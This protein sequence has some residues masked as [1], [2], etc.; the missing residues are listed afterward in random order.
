MKLTLSAAALAV[1]LAFAGCANS[2]VQ[3][4][5]E[6]AT[7]RDTVRRAETDPQVLSGAPLELKRATDALSKANTLF[8]KREP[9]S[10]VVSAA[11]VAQREAEAALTI[12]QAKRAEQATQQAK[13]SRAET[14]AD[15]KGAEAE[16]ARAEAATAQARA[17]TA[18]GAAMAA[19]ARADSASVQAASAQATAAALAAQLAELQAKQTERGMLVTLG[20][21]LFEF[22]RAEIKPTAQA[23]LRKLAEFLQKH[24]ERNVL[25]EGYTDNVGSATY[26]ATLS[27]RRAEAVAVALAGLGISSQ[28]IKSVGYGK[29]F[30]VAENTTDTNRALNRRVEVYISQGTEPVRGRG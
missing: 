5:A 10:D 6:L 25:I 1:T 3:P 12:A 15:L 27:Q 23:E 24:P 22:N 29:D 2:P 21:V 9:N 19:E 30:P 16:R 4:P 7:A 28:R 17:N 14:M 8:A 20:D 11:Y 13:I 26:N 18:S